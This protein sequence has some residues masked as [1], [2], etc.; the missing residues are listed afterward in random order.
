MESLWDTHLTAAVVCPAVSQ[1]RES[2]DQTEAAVHRRLT[3]LEQVRADSAPWEAG[4]AELAGWLT[5]L[6]VRVDQLPPMGHTADMLD[7]QIKE[8]KVGTLSERLEKED[9][10]ALMQLIVCERKGTM[11]EL[12]RWRI[13]LL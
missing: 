9:V 1:L 10:A 4:R 5:R 2:W 3:Q 13:V 12:D 11:A 7:A 8:Q 6:E